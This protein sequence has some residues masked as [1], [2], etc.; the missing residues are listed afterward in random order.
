MSKR[1]EDVVEIV[2]RYPLGELVTIGG[3]E[4]TRADHIGMLRCGPLS[5]E[6]QT[7]VACEDVAVPMQAGKVAVIGEGTESA[8]NADAGYCHDPDTR[9]LAVRMADQYDG[10]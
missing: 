4:M 5:T 1:P 7:F 10:Y 6:P 8:I 9:R 3:A 2:R